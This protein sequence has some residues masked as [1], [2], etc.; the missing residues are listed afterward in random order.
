[1]IFKQD[2]FSL[3]KSKSIEVSCYFSVICNFSFHIQNLNTIYT[4]FIKGL[5]SINV[6]LPE[7]VAICFSNNYKILVFLN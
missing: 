7:N 5:I 3:V 4:S 2:M 6:F 1:M